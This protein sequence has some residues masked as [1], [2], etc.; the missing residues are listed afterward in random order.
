MN[1]QGDDTGA[2]ILKWNKKSTIDIKLY[3]SVPKRKF[4]EA[5]DNGSSW[6][7]IYQ[8][9]IRK[10]NLKLWFILLQKCDIILYIDT[11]ILNLM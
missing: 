5:D 4:V 7:N 11:M 10:N 3:Q 2:I 1:G 6:I 8:T 9:F